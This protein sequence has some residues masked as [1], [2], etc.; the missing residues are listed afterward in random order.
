VKKETPTR[1]TIWINGTVSL[2][3]QEYNMASIH[4]HHKTDTEAAEALLTLARKEGS[5]ILLTHYICKEF[6]CAVYGWT[7]PESITI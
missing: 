2:Q 3:S 1:W 5:A 6:L 7:R 4:S